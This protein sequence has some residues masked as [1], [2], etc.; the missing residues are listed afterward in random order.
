MALYLNLKPGDSVSFDS[1][2]ATVHLE[3]REGQG[4]RLR[5][6]ADRSVEIKHNRSAN[7]AATLAAQGLSKPGRLKAAT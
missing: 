3:K 7:P 1:G 2:P 4:A 6:E 5:I